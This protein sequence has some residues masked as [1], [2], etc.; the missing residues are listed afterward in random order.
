[1][2]HGDRSLGVVA[3]K[4]TYDRLVPEGAD[5]LIIGAPMSLTGRYATMGRL[6]AAGLR[7][8]AEDAAHAG[9]V[10]VSGKRRVPEVVIVDDASTRSGVRRALGLLAQ[11]DLLVGPYG[12]DL[13]AAAGAW[14]LARG[15]LIWNHGGSADDV[16]RLRSVIS[17]SSPASVYLRTVLEAVAQRIPGATVIVAIGRGAFGRAAAEGA[18]EAGR[19]FGADD[20]SVLRHHEVPDEPDVDIVLAA[21]SFADDIALVE[22]L[23]RRPPVLAAVGAGV[24]GFDAAGD[25]E[26]VLA[27]SQWEEAV[28]FQVDTGPRSADVLR[29]L[30]ARMIPFLTAGR[31]SS[32]I[33]YPVAQ[34][35]AAGLIALRCV[36][37]VGVVDDG[38]LADAARRLR[39]TTFFGRFGLGPDGCQVD[40][41][42]VVSQWRHGSRWLVWP[43]SLADAGA[44]IDARS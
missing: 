27:P 11:A 41:A 32:H 4:P 36:E 23:R 28:R 31:S 2:C 7:Q 6:A 26:G 29:S 18:V 8:M 30:R 22:R 34:A 1:M 44:E 10:L 19:R 42:M 12:S 5:P 21:G 40:H 14:G 15:R 43:P 25:V 9:G 35:Y 24:G 39:C 38:A 17:V 37:E 3:T 33:D 13:V 20:V 16:Q